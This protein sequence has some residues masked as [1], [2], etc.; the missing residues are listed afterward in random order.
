NIHA[1][2]ICPQSRIILVFS[3]VAQGTGA[4]IATSPINGY[5]SAG[6]TLELF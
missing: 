6:V 2:E 3:A 1:P 5:A 4:T